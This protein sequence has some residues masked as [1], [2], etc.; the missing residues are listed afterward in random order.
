MK[1]KIA[2]SLV[3]IFSISLIIILSAEVKAAQVC[4]EETKNGDLCRYTDE[5]NCAGDSLKASTTCEQTSFCQLGCGVSTE[6]G[7]CF[8]NLPKAASV[9]QDFTWVEDATCDIP[10]CQKGCCVL[11]NQYS[12]ITQARCKKETSVFPD[13]K[14]DF[15]EEITTEQACLEE[16]LATEEGCC[17]IDQ[18]TCNFGTRSE[19]LK[20][21]GGDAS[22]FK[23]DTLCSN[24]KLS[25]ECTPRHNLGILPGKED[26]YWF[27]S[28]GNPENVLDASQP[29]TGIIKDPTCTASLN[30]PKCGNCDYSLGTVGAEVDTPNG[31]ACISVNCATTTIDPNTPGTGV[32]RRNGESWCVFDDTKGPGQDTVGSRFHRYS[33]IL[34]KEVKEECADF[35]QEFCTQGE[36]LTEVGRFTEA[37]CK[38]NNFESCTAIAKQKDCE[39][40]LVDCQW[41]AD[42]CVP[43]VSPGS[44]FWEDEGSDKC[45]Q[46]S[47]SRTWVYTSGSKPQA[48]I[49]NWISLK[50]AQCNTLG[51]C[52]ENINV[53]GVKGSS[54]F[55]NSE[56]FDTLKKKQSFFERAT[57]S[58][59]LTVGVS[60]LGTGLLLHSIGGVK[61]GMNSVL[62][63]RLFGPEGKDASGFLWHHRTTA[64][65]DGVTDNGYAR[66]VRRGNENK[67]E[68]IKDKKLYSLSPDQKIAAGGDWKELSDSARSGLSPEVSESLTGKTYYKVPEDIKLDRIDPL[69]GDIDFKE[70]TYIS[71]KP[72]VSIGNALAW[73]GTAYTL[74]TLY[75][76]YANR[77]KEKKEVTVSVT[78]SSWQAPTGGKDCE[79]CDDNPDKPCTEYKCKS[80]G[81]LCDLINAG[82]GNETCVSTSPKDSTSPV[83]TSNENALQ[84]SNTLTKTTFPGG[85]EGFKINELIEPYSPVSFG[86]L[87]DEPAQCKLSFQQGI[88]YENM[89]ENS[90]FFGNN[91]F[92]ID[93]R[94][95]LNLPLDA[96]TNELAIKNGGIYTLYARCQ[97]KGGNTNDKDYFIQFQIKAG[98]DL[99]A[100]VIEVT[101]FPPNAQ[102]PH[103]VT[104]TP[105][106]V[107]LNEPS[108]CRY[109]FSDRDYDQMTNDFTCSSVIT[110]VFY[111]LYE[112]K[113]DLVGLN[114]AQDNIIY[115]RCRDQPAAQL[116]DRNTNSESYIQVL[117]PS[118]P[119]KIVSL[120]PSGQVYK[121]SATLEVKTAD[122]AERDGTA[123]CGFSRTQ[124]NFILF[125]QTNTSIHIQ[126]LVNL[127]KA[128]Y[129]YYIQCIDLAN[130]I[131]SD[132]IEFEITVDNKPPEIIN[133]YKD[134]TTATQLLHL[135]TDEPS[136]CEYSTTG[137]LEIG[138]GKLMT[139]TDVTEHDAVLDSDTYYIRCKDTANNQMSLITLYL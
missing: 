72:T 55:D 14:L 101:S 130:N 47:D 85:F 26:V 88:A 84:K 9:A 98:P 15:R 8:E 1:S 44:K 17:A 74:Y 105:Y 78:C 56:G 110:P 76:S 11:N 18:N 50:S 66:Y 102:I 6:E 29:D 13:L 37:K 16:A 22:K 52:G 54:T 126:N 129:T 61:E 73:V 125:A 58:S 118:D 82:T 138:G 108:E 83:I 117:K 38:A 60:L 86:I 51:D 2:L 137:R 80:L 95:A 5:S 121:D 49:E 119:L 23:K 62:S 69:G 120:S 81:Q 92:T 77:E 115:T 43:F 75:D 107:F 79:K 87:T 46:G 41:L 90:V 34:G 123:Q 31:F 122:G 139:G 64:L 24:E 135:V 100:P 40:E 35:R 99:T 114:S 94:V 127:P 112:C 30:D 93:H 70:G 134:T 109:S 12:F 4:C 7:L 71:S 33:C 116:I 97:D 27:D 106:S 63:E 104:T 42:K 103:D 39:A 32:P 113:T 36:K 65:P 132:K 57:K 53:I 128:A 20:L 91:L 133:I 25:C 131:V 21:S 111:G 96:A 124:S 68:F 48:E 10:Q 136:T 59:L 45:A 89:K 28:C 67:F 3:I 19:C